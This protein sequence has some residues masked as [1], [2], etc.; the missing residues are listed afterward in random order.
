MLVL[1]MSRVYGF[2]E[3][4]KLMISVAFSLCWSESLC[5][6]GCGCWLPGLFLHLMRRREEN[7]GSL[8]PG[9]SLF[10]PW[11]PLAMRTMASL[12]CYVVRWRCT[13]ATKYINDAFITERLVASVSS[14]ADWT[15]CD[16]PV[17]SVSAE[18]FSFAFMQSGRMA[19]ANRRSRMTHRGPTGRTGCRGG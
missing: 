9:L 13:K 7:V 1:V 4:G 8:Q 11:E 18:S 6:N 10:W 19:K 3:N 17:W 2:A 14:S 12:S 5:A 16:E 15:R